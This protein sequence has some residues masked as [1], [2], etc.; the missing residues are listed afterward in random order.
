[1]H[2]EEPGDLWFA[3]CR[4][5]Q[6]AQQLWR[7]GRPVPLRPSVWSLLMVFLARPGALLTTEQLMEALWPGVAV[8][9][10]ALTNRIAELRQAL[11]DLT[12]PPRL[13]QT[14]PRRGYRL[15][16]QPRAAMGA[17]DPAPAGVP[18]PGGAVSFDAL[19]TH[20]AH[21]RNGQRRVVLVGGEPGMGKTWLVD[22]F[23]AALPADAMVVGRGQC[24]G[25]SSERESFGP[26]LALLAALCAG[27][28]AAT[29]VPLLRRCAPSWLLQLPWLQDADEAAAL[30]Q[31][32]AGAATGRMLREGCALF[33][34]LAQHSP[35]VLL[36]ED[37]HW[38]DA[39]SID[40][41]HYLLEGRTPAR[42][43]VVATW[44]PVD[45]QLQAHPLAALVQTASLPALPLHLLPLQPLDDTACVQL[46]RAH[47]GDADLAL[48][49]LPAVQ[50]M[51]Q[52]NPLLALAAAQ[53]LRG[54]GALQ[55]DASALGAAALVPGQLR[56]V[57]AAR[58]AA[59]T[60]AERALLRAASV[61]GP[62]FTPLLLA[63]AL[64]A[65]VA[66]LAQACEA[67][68]AR[69]LF[70]RGQADAADPDRHAF[71][72]E[73]YRQAVYDTVPLAE[74]QQMHGRV[75]RRIELAAG[76]AWQP[77]AAALAGAYMRAA[78]PAD[79]ARLLE[80][81]AEVSL[82]RF[83]HRAAEQALQTALQQLAMVQPA[84]EAVLR[85]QLRLQL[86]RG[87]VLLVVRVGHPEAALAYAAAEVLATVVGDSR[88]R[89]RA[90]LGLCLTQ[91]LQGRLRDAVANAAVLVPLAE[92]AQPGLAAAAHTYAGVATLGY[93]QLDTARRHFERAL[94]LPFDPDVPVFVDL[95][96]LA[97][98]NL[99]R[100][101]IE[102]G[103]RGDGLR[104][105]EAGLARSRTRA[106]AQDLLQ[107]L[108]W[109]ADAH[110]AAGDL[111]AATALYAEARTHAEQLAVDGYALAAQFGL[112]A[113]ETGR[114]GRTASMAALLDAR[115]ALGE[116][117]NAAGFDLVLA[118]A[119]WVDG[120]TDGCRRSVARGLARQ[121]PE[122]GTRYQADLRRLVMQADNPAAAAA[123]PMSRFDAASWRGDDGSTAALRD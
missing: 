108:Y 81:T 46:L 12:H 36:V 120:D 80:R 53:H 11:D 70:I 99:G 4:L 85:T 20:L 32:L 123:H 55:A 107:T 29:V 51:A 13:I 82:G 117:W 9:P 27:P 96:A 62:S 26:W 91:V 34:A 52:G 58:L 63:A 22:R 38:A 25:Q 98:L 67:L 83:D 68:A 45:A 31:D 95:P 89:V 35:L 30:R 2:T 79:A 40:L 109:A 47:L 65:E 115:Q 113:S 50:R 102:Q 116:S 103:A 86:M 110:R 49:L 1:M 90:L 94:Q 18:A 5:D 21:A 3:D 17:P 37:L 60:E 78:M 33:E 88:G 64:E 15:L 44:R 61:V 73:A 8:T 122:G 112:L 43:L 16:V 28:A 75:A 93:G 118:Q 101:L 41:L 69:Q 42:L 76:T 111:E 121:G 48:Q 57:V 92:L 23:A 114:A 7:A 54:G 84:S 39:A 6:R 10:K 56:Q 77:V 19:V 106:L 87:N 105:V 71:V 66:P 72:H 97:Q 119:C 59:L 100:T 14:V 104:H 74:R 24:I